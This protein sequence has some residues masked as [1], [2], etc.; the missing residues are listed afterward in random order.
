V[1]NE[2]NPKGDETLP[3]F[4]LRR[5][6]HYQRI[7]R[8]PEERERR[9]AFGGYFSIQVSDLTLLYTLHVT[10]NLITRLIL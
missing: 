1:N 8:K 2:Y 3:L 9:E 4:R 5:S 7:L 10:P 6:S